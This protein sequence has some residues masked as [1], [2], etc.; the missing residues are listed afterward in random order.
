MAFPIAKKASAFF[1]KPAPVE[2]HKVIAVTGGGSASFETTA[3][4]ESCP[5]VCTYKCDV[6]QNGIANGIIRT[7]H[8]THTQLSLLS[9]QF[10]LFLNALF[11]AIYI[12]EPIIKERKKETTKDC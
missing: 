1:R 11:R 3:C 7:K 6:R 9:K 5:H 4:C 8:K 12:K 2:S 10:L